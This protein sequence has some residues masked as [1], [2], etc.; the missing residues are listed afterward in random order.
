MPSCFYVFCNY[1]DVNHF[2]L[3]AAFKIMRRALAK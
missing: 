3:D 1:N 2:Y